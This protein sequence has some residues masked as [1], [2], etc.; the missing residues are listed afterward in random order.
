MAYNSISSLALTTINSLTHPKVAQKIADNITNVAFTNSFFDGV[1]DLSLNSIYELATIDGA[2]S[3]S[4]LSSINDYVCH[5]LV[6]L[7]V[8]HVPL[9]C[10]AN[11]LLRISLVHHAGNEIVVLLLF[12]SRRLLTEGNNW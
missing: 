9:D 10:K 1:S 4:I 3:F 11:L 6:V 5:I 12:L 7:P 8:A 2:L